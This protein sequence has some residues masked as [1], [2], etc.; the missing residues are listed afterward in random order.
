MVKKMLLLFCLAGCLNV[1]REYAR[2]KIGMHTDQVIKA[3]GQ[4]ERI[5]TMALG[6][7]WFYEDHLIEII[8]DTVESCMTKDEW[9]KTSMDQE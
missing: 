6:Q 2:V 8:S 7:R 5:D 1:H 9:E 4:P 3:I